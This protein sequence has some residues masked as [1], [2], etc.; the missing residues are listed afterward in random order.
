MNKNSKKTLE[1]QLT[2]AEVALH[3]VQRALASGDQDLLYKVRTRF[4]GLVNAY[5]GDVNA[6]AMLHMLI[7]E[8]SI[9]AKVASEAQHVSGTNTTSI[10]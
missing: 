1:R 6:T 3:N 10:H 9:K 4:D 8:L 5:K 7:A 2:Q